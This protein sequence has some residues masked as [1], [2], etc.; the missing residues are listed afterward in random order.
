MKPL[1]IRPSDAVVRVVGESLCLVAERT[2]KEF[3]D[4]EVTEWCASFAACDP[5]EL[6]QAF[7]NVSL[8]SPFAPSPAS[9]FQELDRLRFGGV[10][11]AWLLV[12]KTALDC[13][14]GDF[15]V[16]F[17]HAGIHFAVEVL[18]G[19]SGT[20]SLVR[21]SKRAGF[22]QRDFEKAFRDY[23]TPNSYPAGL[24][25]FNGRNAVLIGH[26]GRA[27]DVYRRGVKLGQAFFLGAEALQPQITLLPWER[28]ESWPDQLEVGHMAAQPGPPIYVSPVWLDEKPGGSS[29]AI[30]SNDNGK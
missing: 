28:P 30:G 1:A 17:E 8:H 15:F 29:L 22:A 7:D 27:L 26:R 11:G 3:G 4:L 10:S 21:D 20:I 14:G 5:V 2:G 9:V 19:W 23:R 25:T 13:A 6:R 12:R 18:G 24:G 16:V